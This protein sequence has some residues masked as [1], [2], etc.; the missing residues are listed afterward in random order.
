MRKTS[1]LTNTNAS[2]WQKP[3]DM[4]SHIVPSF[5]LNGGTGLG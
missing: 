4:Y 2:A 1:E 3:A 5:N